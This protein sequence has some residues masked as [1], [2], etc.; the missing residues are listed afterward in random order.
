MPAAAT[1]NMQ[2]SEGWPVHRFPDYQFDAPAVMQHPCIA[3]DLI[4][5]TSQRSRSMMSLHARIPSS[6]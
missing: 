1:D 4:V 5:F 3:G 2:S 6:S